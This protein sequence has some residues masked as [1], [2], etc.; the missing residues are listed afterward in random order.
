[1]GKKRI[2]LSSS[3]MG[4]SEKQYIDQ[5]F[6]DNLVT[7]FGPNV[8][9]FEKTFESY[10][11]ENGDEVYVAA[12]NSG[13]A[14]IHLGLLLL[15]VGKGDEVLVQSHTHIASANPVVY[16]G[17]TPVF[18]DSE[19]KTWNMCPDALE[20]AIQHRILN[21]ITPKAIITANLYGMPYDAGRINAIA[22]R[23]QIPVLED[24][25][26]SLGSSY[27][28]NH[29]GT[30]GDIGALSFNGNKIITT[31]G[32]GLLIVKTKAMRDRAIYLATQAKEQL[33]YYE[34]AEIGYN[35]RMSNIAAGIGRGQMEVLADRVVAR[36]A[37]HLFYRGIFGSVKGVRVLQEPE[38]S[39][40]SNHWLSCILLDEGV[41]PEGTAEALRRFLDA[42]G[43]ESR[44]LWKPMHL[45]PVFESARYFGEDVAERLFKNGLCLPSGSNLDE[46]DRLQIRRSIEVFFANPQI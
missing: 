34:H 2:W 23:Y 9:A 44:R 1:M 13:T 17:A 29:C 39:Y 41:F 5:A 19:S 14:A 24:A 10:L 4:G 20:N 22:A 38:E 45:Q 21:G 25:A 7:S 12:L 46:T 26:E 18:I 33:P 31:S 30:L 36:R 16:C 27:D 11:S 35:Y 32:G 15:G 6:A 42:N 37:M 8:D 28:G 3:H 40:L 43:I